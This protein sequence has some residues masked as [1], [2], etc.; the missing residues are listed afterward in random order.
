MN[1]PE[2]TFEQAYQEL[3]ALVE[4]LEAGNLSLEE[5]LNLYERGQVL[6]RWCN[7]QLDNAELRITQISA[8][9]E[10]ENED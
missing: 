1:N 9:A 10:P 3:V 4:R 6:S 7:A 2:L 8:D 5:S